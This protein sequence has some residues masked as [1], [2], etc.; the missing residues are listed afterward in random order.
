MLGYLSFP[1]LRFLSPLYANFVLPYQFKNSHLNKKGRL[2]LPFIAFYNPSMT[3]FVLMLIV[4]IAWRAVRVVVMCMLAMFV[5]TM[6]VAL[7]MLVMVVRMFVMVC[8]IGMAFM[9]G[10][11]FLGV[12]FMI[13]MAVAMSVMCVS[14]MV[15]MSTYAVHDWHKQRRRHT[16]DDHNNTAKNSQIKSLNLLAK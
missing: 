13:G 5:L 4:L 9:I 14:V 7:V 11:A 3:V 12:A 16:S 15:V 2:S 6:V 8:V 1:N 10:M